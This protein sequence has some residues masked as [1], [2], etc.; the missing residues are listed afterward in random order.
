MPKGDAV[1]VNCPHC[2]KASTYRLRNDNANQ[3]DTC[4]HCSKN[5]TIC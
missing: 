1:V 4:P 2:G 3:V 5:F